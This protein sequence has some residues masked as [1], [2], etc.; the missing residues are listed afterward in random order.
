MNKNILGKFFI[1]F[2][3]TILLSSCQKNDYNYVTESSTGH[4]LNSFTKEEKKALDNGY[5]VG[6]YTIF[7]TENNKKSTQDV[8][9]FLEN[10]F[11]E[12][13][14]LDAESQINPAKKINII[15]Y[16]MHYSPE[17]E[18]FNLGVFLVNTSHENIQSI[19][20]KVKPTFKNITDGEFG[21]IEYNKKDFIDLPNNGAIPKAISANA[22]IEYL[23]KL[24]ENTGSDI[25]FEIKD[26]E[27]NGEKVN[28][29]NEN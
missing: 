12:K 24:K 4:T 19:K 9:T 20:M 21:E 10:N 3:F 15:T 2:L 28:N 25:T 26:L 14:F 1:L 23:D 16:A 5:P 18:R 29:K 13:G 7:L 22:P 11:F 17:E 6:K 8:T 27:I